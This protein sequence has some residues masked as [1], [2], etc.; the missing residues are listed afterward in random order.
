M[1][2]TTCGW[3]YITEWIDKPRAKR[4]HEISRCSPIA[5]GILAI[6]AHATGVPWF[7]GRGI[8]IRATARSSRQ[9]IKTT[10]SLA[11]SIAAYE[12]HAAGLES[13]LATLDD[14]RWE[15]KARL[16]MDGK[17]MWETTL[18]EMLF[19]F[20]FDAVHHRGQISSYLRPMGAKVPSIYG[21]SGDDP[22]TGG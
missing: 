20:L 19:G 6:D 18:G 7:G 14:E 12:R 22:G 4:R 3:H 1:R 13:R 21:P 15:S 10:T 8:T 16:L 2:R 17:P 11:D 5:H 9:N